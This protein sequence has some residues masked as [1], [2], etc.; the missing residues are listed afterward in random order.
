[1]LDNELMTLNQKQTGPIKFWQKGNNP[2]VLI[3][4]GTHG[5][6]WRVIEPTTEYILANADSLPDFIYV[7][8]VS[9]S[10]VASKTRVNGNN[11]D[12]NRNF[13]DHS[14]DEEIKANLEILNSHDFTKTLSIHE[15]IGYKEFYLYDSG[16]IKKEEWQEFIL[17]LKE[18]DIDVLN[19]LDDPED[20]VLGTV[21]K[22]GYFSTS[23][24]DLSKSN[25]GTLSEYLAINK[26]QA[27]YFTIEVPTQST[28]QQKKL[29][30]ELI[31]PALLYD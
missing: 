24:L 26:D 13:F 9:P 18:I 23:H 8:E 31:F 14:S 30:I 6:E 15:D 1:M 3:H 29:L 19:G 28:S 25:F 10:A 16:V 27:R 11:L 17:K 21:F 5:D 4:T 20:P 12:L 7:P 22:D 2:E